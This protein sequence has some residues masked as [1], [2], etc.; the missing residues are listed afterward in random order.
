[1][2]SCIGELQDILIFSQLHDLHNTTHYKP[3]QQ[4]VQHVLTRRCQQLP[5]EIQQHI[6]NENQ[7]AYMHLLFINLYGHHKSKNEFNL[8]KWNLWKDLEVH[9]SKTIIIKGCGSHRGTRGSKI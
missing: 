9:V 4:H 1:M 5:L 6:N 8:L 2:T 3:L 7:G